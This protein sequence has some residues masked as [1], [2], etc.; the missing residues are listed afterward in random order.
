MEHV[1]GR[2]LAERI[3]RRGLPLREV[4]RLGSQIAEA[5]A[6]A[7]ARGIVHRDLKPNN[8][9]V[10][11]EGVVKVLDFGLA[12]LVET[13]VSEDAATDLN[14]PT[15]EGTVVG[16]AAYMSPEQAHGQRVD[17]L[18]ERGDLAVERGR[19]EPPAADVDGGAP[20]RQ[21]ALVPGRQVDRLRLTPRR[22]CR[23][24]SRQPRGRRATP[25]D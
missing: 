1:E 9:M 7:H 13:E 6:Q 24:V 18:G 12:K 22:H 10:T 2:T 5:L 16:T 21:P 19:I 15:G 8:V 23:S 25:S 3:G 14:P 20:H 17:P 11:P 4:L